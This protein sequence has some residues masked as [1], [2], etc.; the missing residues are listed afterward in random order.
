MQVCGGNDSHHK[1]PHNVAQRK[2]KGSDVAMSNWRLA[3]VGGNAMIKGSQSSTKFCTK[4]H[5]GETDIAGN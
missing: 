1:G 4:F 5:E 3:F 2:S